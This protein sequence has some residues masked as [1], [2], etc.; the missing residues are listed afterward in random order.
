V[1][2]AAAAR[3]GILPPRLGQRIGRGRPGASHHLAEQQQL[4]G[5]QPLGAA[6]VQAAQ[7][8]VHLLLKALFLVDQLDHA[9]VLLVDQGVLPPEQFV[10]HGQVGGQRLGGRGCECAI[11][12]DCI[13]YNHIRPGASTKSANSNIFFASRD[14]A[15]LTPGPA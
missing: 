7:Q 6:A 10:A 14:A 2:P 13:L 3:L 8:L 5:V 11:H 12:C 1:G 9:P 4:G 15:R